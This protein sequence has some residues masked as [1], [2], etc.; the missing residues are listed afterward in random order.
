MTDQGKGGYAG[1]C[2]QRR[3][4]LKGLKNA[5]DFFGISISIFGTIRP[6]KIIPTSSKIGI[7]NMLVNTLSS[8]F[9]S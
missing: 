1:V 6:T 8:F 2:F 9:S 5:M 7:T 3:R 4:E